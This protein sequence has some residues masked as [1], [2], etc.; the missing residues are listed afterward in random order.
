VRLIH[1]YSAVFDLG[2]ERKETG[3]MRHRITLAFVAARMRSCTNVSMAY[4]GPIHDGTAFNV[5]W[6]DYGC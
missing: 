4:P 3:A 6:Q 1:N 5:W 2:S